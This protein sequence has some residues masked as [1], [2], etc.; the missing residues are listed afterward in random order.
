VRS[1]LTWLIIVA[2][3]G[4]GVAAAV[5]ALPEGDDDESGP[6]G[7]S[8]GTRE[9]AAALRS[10]GIR[11]L[12]TYSDE[13][14]RLHAVRLP[15]LHATR[16]PAVTS[17]EPHI[18]TG[19]ILA[20]EGDVV[21]SGLGFGTVQIVLSS[22]RVDRSVSRRFRLGGLGLRARQAVA[23]G[24]QRYVVLVEGEAHDRYLAFFEVRRLLIAYELPEGRE[25]DVLRPSP[26]GKYVA[27]LASG[28]PG[29]SVFTR[30]GAG[31]HLPMVS[32][33][34]AIAW[35]PDDNW[36]ALATLE[37]VYVFRSGEEENTLARIPLAVRDLNWGA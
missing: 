23:L 9:A 10:V 15:S 33:P 5:D 2:V 34:R 12:I 19:G 31:V 20:W 32:R 29:V 18:S 1:R 27:L 7:R 22:E 26:G 6:A 21:W 11:G 25:D 24:G 35:S 37:S 36:T 8:P 28:R 3:L 30:S 17:C 13:R 14:C 4:V 16:A